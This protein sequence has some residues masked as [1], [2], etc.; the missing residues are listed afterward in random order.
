MTDDIAISLQNVSK[1][2]K[3]YARPVDRLKEILL[4]QKS[5]AVEF[6]ALRDISLD[7][8]KG[9]TFGLVG[10]NG[11][12]KS[13]LLQIIAGTLQPTTGQV[14]TQGRISALLELGSG[15]NPEFTG[16]QNIIFN[17]RILGLSQ[18]E[19]EQRF[20]AIASFADIG[21]FLEEPVK[22]YSSGM[23]V[24]LAFA[25]AINVQP[26]I[27]IVD[28]ALAVGDIFFQAKC[29]RR[30]EALQD[31]GVT[32]LFVSHDLSTVQNLCKEGVLMDHGKILCRA[33]PSVISSEYFKLFR[34]A[35]EEVK[36]LA[37]DATPEAIFAQ[38][39]GRIEV[40]H[41]QRIT[42]GQ[43]SIQEVY[44]TGLDDR[45]KA[46]FMTGETIKVTLLAKFHETCEKVAGAF[47]L[48][49][50]YG[51]WLAGRHTWYDAPGLI[52]K[53]EAGEVVEF[54]FT[55]QLDFQRGEYLTLVAIVSQRT[56]AD[57]D[58][59]D[60]IQNAFAIQIA[61]QKHH[62]GLTKVPGTVNIYRRS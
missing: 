14:I 37:I 6:W 48:C 27:L 5:R 23:Y 50:R 58:S 35:H 43:A 46:T 2:F 3:R 57:Y 49:D 30:I 36:E 55:L 22:T 20:D 31:S 28:E 16:R 33:E 59:L 21:E 47:G 4:P 62:W 60:L 32:I 38:R 12:G 10:Q 11:S 44:V 29:F 8:P 24:R 52:P 45:A 34:M 56:E 54:E 7:I 41:D 53:V 13:T 19:I 17:G 25:V 26:D 18:E 9:E 15:F 42:N 1:C 51:Q 40:C 39:E 61:G